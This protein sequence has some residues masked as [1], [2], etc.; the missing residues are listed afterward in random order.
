MRV[1]ECA[2]MRDN[3][4][5]TMR[6]QQCGT[7]TLQ[8]CATIRDN[9]TQTISDN[10][11]NN[12]R[13]YKTMIS[14]LRE[15]ARQWIAMPR[16]VDVQYCTIWYD[17]SLRQHT[18][19]YHIALRAAPTPRPIHPQRDPQ[20]NKQRKETLLSAIPARAEK[21]HTRTTTS[22]KGGQQPFLH[23]HHPRR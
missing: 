22:A 13:P 4:K 19:W 1:L 18:I 12:T 2:T 20:L 10:A 3:A 14:T 21:F 7:M 8:Q 16:N 6:R 11:I 9:A 15:N 17:I 23:S 5:A